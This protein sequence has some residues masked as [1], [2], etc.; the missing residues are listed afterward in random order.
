MRTY[1][2]SLLIYLCLYSLVSQAEEYVWGEEFQEGDIISAATFNQIFSTLQKLNRSPVDADLVGTW[3]CSSVHSSTDNMNTNGWVTNNFIDTL[4]NAQLN[5]TASSQPT[6]LSQA[7]SFSTSNP[8]PLIRFSHA[9]V[10]ST[11]TYIL[12][13]NMLLMK[14]VISATGVSKFK[15]DIM[16]DDRFILTSLSDGGN[17]PDLIVCDSATPVPAAPTGTKATNAQ[18]TVNVSWTD[19]STD[20]T[21][22]KIYR[23]LSNETSETQ[24]VTAVTASPYIDSSL[25]EGQT[26]YYRVSAY[27]SNGESSKSGVAS[28]TLD[29]IKPTVIS[30][31]PTT[32]QQVTTT[33]RSGS[34]IFSE[35]IQVIC[36]ADGSTSSGIACTT[37]GS[38]MTVTGSSGK[39][40][41]IFLFPGDS[42]VSFTGNFAG[43]AETL[44]S[45][46][47]ITVTIH[48]EWVRDING[49][50][51]NS[52]YS[53]SFTTGSGSG[54]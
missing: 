11:G 3:S 38:A 24:L 27:N 23:R 16:S 8:S 6:S 29:N 37:P 54:Y 43:S 22:F 53:Y 46:D 35:N 32:N 25:S 49:N 28:A 26:A 4:S 7:Y 13:R 18:T 9:S 12:Y 14:G 17:Y 5:M 39:N 50:Q 20:E 19:Q 42:S 1:S 51:M 52:D 33:S 41:G 45:N 31:T 44:N 21:G 34:I 15:I 30:H 2:K 10:S 40:Y 36:P 48:K 47:T